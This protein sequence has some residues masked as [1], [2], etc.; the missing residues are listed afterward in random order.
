MGGSIMS[1]KED[2][3]NDC[4][5]WAGGSSCMCN[6]CIR[7]MNLDDYYEPEKK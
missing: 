5:H 3:R 7:N 4:I 6:E 1:E 2:C